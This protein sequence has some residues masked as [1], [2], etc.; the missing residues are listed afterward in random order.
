[1]AART[2]EID[3]DNSQHSIKIQYFQ[4]PRY[5][6][7]L[8]LFAGLQNSKAEIFPGNNFVL[9]TPHMQN[10]MLWL[11]ITAAFILLLAIFIIS[12]RRRQNKT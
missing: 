2:G 1:V 4:G 7:A 11:C 6:I 10:N 8:Q 9:S 5:Q 3:L 12:K